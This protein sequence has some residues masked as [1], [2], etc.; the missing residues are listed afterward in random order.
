MPVMLRSF[1]S[2]L[3]YSG[4][5]TGL[6]SLV[7]SAVALILSV[8]CSVSWHSSMDF[9]ILLESVGSLNRVFHAYNCILNQLL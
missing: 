2:I 1:L 9:V 6:A 7:F 3:L 4:F 8:M 5:F